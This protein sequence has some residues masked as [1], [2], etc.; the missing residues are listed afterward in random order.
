MEAKREA[1]ITSPEKHRTRADI[2]PLLRALRTALEELYGDRLAKLILYGSFA[3][4]EA[5]EGSDVDVMVSYTATSTLGTRSSA[6]PMPP[7]RFSS[8]TK[9]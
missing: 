1:D 5:W 7:I 4:G 9:N 3:R 2:E 6:R 8:N